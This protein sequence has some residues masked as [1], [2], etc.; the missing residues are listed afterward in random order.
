VATRFVAYGWNVTRVSDANDLEM[1]ERAFR[2]FKSTS[3]RPTLVIVDSIIGYGAPHKQ[4]TA[5]AHSDALDEEEVRLA[6][7]SYGWPE[8]AQ[9]LIPDGADERFRDGIGKRGHALREAWQKTFE[10]YGRKH[11]QSATQISQ[12]MSRDLPKDWDANLPIFRLTIKV[13]PPKP[14]A[15]STIAA[16]VPWL[17]GARR[18]SRPRPRRTCLTAPALW[19][20][21]SRGSSFRGTRTR[22]GGRR[23]R[24]VLSNCALSARPS[25]SSAIICGLRPARGI[26]E[27]AGVPRLHP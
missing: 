27:V 6:K 15:S 17:I 4:D 22:D 2:T 3:D 9:F 11:R 12:L 14:P 25:S 10:D 8:D 1:L 26:D 16:H 7:R 20:Q 19:R 18:T 23:E 13:S 21:A 24:P 5:A